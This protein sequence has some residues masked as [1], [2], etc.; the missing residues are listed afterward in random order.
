MILS[1]T[2]SFLGTALIGSPEALK[3]RTG[4]NISPEFY[5]LAVDRQMPL[6]Y[7]EATMRDKFEEDNFRRKLNSK[8]A[9]LSAVFCLVIGYGVLGQ[10]IPRAAEGTKYAVQKAKSVAAQMG[11]EDAKR[12]RIKELVKRSDEIVHKSKTGAITQA[13]EQEYKELEREFNELKGRKQ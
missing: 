10:L 3:E 1:K 11:S 13:E 12:T 7:T 6:N 9:V 5:Y 8:L 2:L 4:I